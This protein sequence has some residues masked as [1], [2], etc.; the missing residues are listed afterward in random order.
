M[1][2][3]LVGEHVGHDA[4]LDEPLE[5]LDLVAHPAD[6]PGLLAPLQVQ[7]QVDGLVEALGPHVKVARGQAL[8]D[9]RG[10][11]VGRQEGG[12]VHDRRQGLGPAHA[13]ETPADH[14]P[15]VERPAEALLGHRREGLVGALHDALAADVDPRTGGH[16]AVHHQARALEL[17]EVLPG[18]P[19]PHQVAV[20]DQHPRR[21]GVRAEHA[22]RPARL[23]QQ[24]L[25]GVHLPQRGDDAVE[26]A[27]GAR[28]APR[29]AVHDQVL[30]ILGHLGIE[31][32]HQH[33]Q[34]RL[35]EPALAAQLGAAGR[36]DGVAGRGGHARGLGHG[37]LD[38]VAWRGEGPILRAP[39]GG[40]Q[41]GVRPCGVRGI[42]AIPRAPPRP[43]ARDR[44]GPAAAAPRGGPLRTARAGPAHAT[45]RARRAPR[46]ARRP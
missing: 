4:A 24:R 34:R 30:G 44:P 27:P 19:A 41:P 22:H 17:V 15:P 13:P 12:A 9:A 29:A 26:V 46:P 37:D 28:G 25:V 6:G 38:A 7:G 39:R 36:H 3:G 32:V 31:V 23:H 43:A 20:G 40:V 21:V 5:Q 18:G 10:V 33:P 8:L 11:D 42:A 45:G 2:A 16:L 1:G 35:G 14:Q